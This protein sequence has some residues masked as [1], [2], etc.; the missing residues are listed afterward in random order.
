MLPF[1]LIVLG[2][3]MLWLV[4][5]DIAAEELIIILFVRRFGV[6]ITNFSIF[7]SKICWYLP[8]QYYNIKVYYLAGNSSIYY[9]YMLI[10]AVHFHKVHVCF[11]NV[12]R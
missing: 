8:E 4:I 10:Y 7:I 9:S 12:I 2:C 3:R 5:F 1:V 6:T 11:M